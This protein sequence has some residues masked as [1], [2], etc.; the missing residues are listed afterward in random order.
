MWIMNLVQ[1]SGLKGISKL[2][3][4]SLETCN[5]KCGKIEFRTFFDKNKNKVNVMHLYDGNDTKYFFN[6]FANLFPEFGDFACDVDN[7]MFCFNHNE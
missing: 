5:G 2:M 4:L 6:V 7:D 3:S 1:L